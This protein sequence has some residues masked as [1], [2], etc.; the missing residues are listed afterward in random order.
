[1]NSILQSLRLSY[2]LLERAGT[3]FLLRYHQTPQ[4]NPYFV[5]PHVWLPSV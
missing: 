3:F 4:A 2:H 1:M 5:D